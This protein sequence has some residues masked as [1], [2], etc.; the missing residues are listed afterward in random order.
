MQRTAEAPEYRPIRLATLQQELRSL[1]E[2]RHQAETD[3]S[4]DGDR[5]AIEVGY[6]D[7]IIR[8]LEERL[9]QLKADLRCVGGSP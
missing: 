1:Q 5:R 3:P 8:W 7:W 4:L 2:K 6:Y 9:A